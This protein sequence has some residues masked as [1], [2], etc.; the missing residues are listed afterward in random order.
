MLIIRLD[1]YFYQ[2]LSLTLKGNFQARKEFLVA[3][4]ACEDG[5]VG[6]VAVLAFLKVRILVF[7]SSEEG[8]EKCEESQPDFDHGEEHCL[9]CLGEFPGL[10]VGHDDMEDVPERVWLVEIA[11]GAENDELDDSVSVDHAA[12]V[13]EPTY[14]QLLALAVGNQEVGQAD[15]IVHHLLGDCG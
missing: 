4:Y 5:K 15:V 10:V 12:E 7:L 8:R 13:D 1:I 14:E 2:E 6:D 9:F 11:A 3:A